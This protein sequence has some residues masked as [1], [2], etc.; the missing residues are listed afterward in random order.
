MSCQ[1]FKENH[2]NCTECNRKSIIPAEE[3]KC[4]YF[5]RNPNRR[6][7]CK[8][9]VDGCVI[10]EI[11]DKKKCDYLIVSCQTAIAFFIELKGSD[12]S[13]VID[14]LDQSVDELKDKISGF[15]INARVVLSRSDNPAIGTHK[16]E[17]FVKKIH[18]LGGT[19]EIKN[20]VME[21]ILS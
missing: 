5:L 10:A 17:K 2:P 8:I 21:E 3:K 9:R 20:K 6:E 13:V 16:Y 19:L 1:H 4:K 7:V 11:E 14:Q 15:A 18:R 12:L